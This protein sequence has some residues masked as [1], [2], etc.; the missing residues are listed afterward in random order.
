[1]YGEC[2]RRYMENQYGD[3]RE[4]KGCGHM[5]SRST[6]GVKNEC[7]HGRNMNCMHA[8]GHKFSRRQEW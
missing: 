6:D 5:E 1:M 4:I 7:N 2:N 3:R 8:R